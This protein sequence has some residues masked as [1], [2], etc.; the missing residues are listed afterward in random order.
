MRLEYF[1]L[2]LIAASG[3]H[4]NSVNSPPLAAPN[5]D[6]AVSYP[7]IDAQLGEHLFPD[8]RAIAGELSGLIEESIRRQYSAGNARR[9]AHPKAHGC[10]KAEISILDTLPAALSKGMLIPGTTYQAWIRFS[11][12]SGDPTRADIKRDAR[13]MAI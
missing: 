11:N 13:G 6:G 2:F 9:D 3:C 5:R 12:G 8:E 4:T 1:A 7:S 10:V